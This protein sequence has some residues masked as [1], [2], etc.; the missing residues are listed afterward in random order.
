MRV[1]AGVTVWRAVTAQRYAA[2]LACAQMNPLGADLHTFV[3]FAALRL[4][5]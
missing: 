1:F 5:N 2:R 4:F 3:A